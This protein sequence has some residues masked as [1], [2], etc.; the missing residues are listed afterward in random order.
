MHLT[1][2]KTTLT[3]VNPANSRTV[4][5]RSALLTVAVAPSAAACGSDEPTGIDHSQVVGSYQATSFIVTEGGTARDILDEGGSITLVREE[6]GTTSGHAI[7]PDE[8]C[9]GALIDQ[10]LTGTWSLADGVVTLQ[11]E[12]DT[13]LRDLPLQASSDQLTADATFDDVR[14][15]LTLKRLELLCGRVLDERATGAER[16]SAG[17]GA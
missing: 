6:G 5:L 8:E 2:T 7:V 14:V 1:S 3:P 16:L 15:Q 4:I 13:F 17:R 12:T 9:G 10:D 11:M